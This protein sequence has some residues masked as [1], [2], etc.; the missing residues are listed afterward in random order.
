MFRRTITRVAAIGLLF[1]AVA[2]A[3]T[4]ASTPA[5]DAEAIRIAQEVTTAGAKMFAAKDAQGLADTYIDEGRIILVSRE[6]GT[7]GLKRDVREGRSAV[8]EGYKELFKSPDAISAVN[9]L[10]Y[11]RMLG[12]DMLEISGTLVLTDSN[13]MHRFPF[14]QLRVREGNFWRI[15]EVQLFVMTGN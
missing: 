9:R 1:A 8:L 15:A 3:Q 14:T 2:H 6:A 13:G 4:S 10:D 12:T 7:P 11:A 5:G